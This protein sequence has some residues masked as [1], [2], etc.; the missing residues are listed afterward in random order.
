MCIFS[1]LSNNYDG[2]LFVEKVYAKPLAIITKISILD[3]WKSSAYT[4]A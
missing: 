2:D 1:T 3:D 4:F